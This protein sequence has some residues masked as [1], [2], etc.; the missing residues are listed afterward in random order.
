M[1]ITRFPQSCI[2][3]EKAGQQIVIDPGMHFLGTHKTEELFEVAAALYTHQHPDHYEPSI[4]DSLLQKG[5]ALYANSATA[6]LIGK[7][8]CTVVADGESFTVA[9]FNIT[10]HELP[11]CLLPD[12]SAGPQNTGYVIDGVFFHPGDGKEMQAA[13]TIDT[14][15]L[16]ITGPDVSLLDSFNFAKKLGARL[17]I[18][19]HFDWMGADPTAYKLFAEGSKMPFEFHPL[20]D[21]ESLEIPDGN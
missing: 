21:G 12:G 1:K 18:P 11:H 7:T 2:L 14:V 6:E 20:S 13:L 17:A 5:K 8:R 4:A 19:I 10:A 16:P 9:G 15:A 3:L